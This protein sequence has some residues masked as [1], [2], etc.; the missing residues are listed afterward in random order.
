VIQHVLLGQEKKDVARINK[1]DSLIQKLISEKKTPGFALGIKIGDSKPITKEYGFA[2]LGANKK[3]TSEHQ[4]RIASLT[5]PFTATA[6]LKLV[7]LEKLS[8]ADKIDKFF[9]LYPNGK[10]ISIYHLLSHT[11]GIPN[12]WEGQ[13]PQNVPKDFP[14]C[15]SPH[16]YLQAMKNHALF[17]PGEFYKY[18]NSGYVLLGEI[19]EITSGQ[20]YEKYLQE[21]VFKPA[22]MSNTGMEYIE[23]V[24]EDFVKG[25]A[26]DSTQNNPF[27]EPMVYHMPFSAGGLRSTASDLLKF[28]KAL[29]EGKIITRE[30]FRKMTSYALLNDG[31]PVYEG[32][33]IVPGSK[34]AKVQAEIERRGYGLGFHLMD[35]YQSPVYFHS[36]GIAG[37]NSYLMHI[38]ESN[39]TIVLLANAEDG[40]IPILKDVRKIA[41]EIANE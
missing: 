11:S 2:D 13:L 3:V 29:K 35:L 1:I 23:K 32:N 25:Y 40:I 10:N 34:P 26:I 8:L 24:S 39:T 41:T 14:M 33:Y 22:G 28:V 37:F 31:K 38:P 36:G 4:F 6:I 9:P 20:D 15:D 19:I 17:E 12:W 5:K 27:V 7:E 21:N 16:Q 30:S 18:S